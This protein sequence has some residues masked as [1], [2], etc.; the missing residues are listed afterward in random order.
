MPQKVGRQGNE[1][2]GLG[3]G[4]SV[5]TYIRN[6]SE[7]ADGRSWQWLRAG[8]LGKSIERYSMFLLPRRRLV[9]KVFGPQFITRMY[10]KS[11]GESA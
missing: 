3:K 1:R 10:S 5:G 9:N 4:D 8:Y 11:K 2:D 6:V 7:V